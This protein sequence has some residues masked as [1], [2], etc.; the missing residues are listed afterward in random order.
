MIQKVSVCLKRFED[1]DLVFWA[2]IRVLEYSLS[3][4][5]QQI[6]VLESLKE[7]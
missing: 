5:A 3:F 1:L 2:L 7:N 6:L 4:N